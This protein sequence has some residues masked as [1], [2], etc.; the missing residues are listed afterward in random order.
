VKALRRAL[1]FVLPLG[2]GGCSVFSGLSQ[3]LVTVLSTA[4]ALA[5]IAIPFVLSYYLYKGKL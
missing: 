3:S 4:I 5:I 2:L 1:L